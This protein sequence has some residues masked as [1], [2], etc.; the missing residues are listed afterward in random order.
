MLSE[1]R[2]R[3]LA[4][5]ESVE[6]HLA[7]GLNVVSGETG[8]GKSLI[9]T[10]V[11]LLLGARAR[12]GLVRHGAKEAIIEGRFLLHGQDLSDLTDL[13]E[14]DAEELVLRRVISPSGSSR[15]YL[16]GNL[17][18]IGL[19][20][21]VGARLV[22]VHGQ[23]QSLAASEEQRR[24]LDAFGNSE[25]LQADWA[26]DHESLRALEERLA[27]AEDEEVSR[28]ER[29]DYLR[30]QIAD[31]EA[32]APEV[33]EEAELEGELRLLEGAEELEAG[34]AEA[35]RRLTED[36][37]AL[38]S[39]CARLA[40]KL[41]DATAGQPVLG[42]LIERLDALAIEADDLG[43]EC[44]RHLDRLDRDPARQGEAEQRLDALRGL[45]RRHRVPA[46]E[47]PARL[48]AL[49]AEADE[50]EGGAAT[51][52]A[53]KAE[54]QTLL[55]RL[56]KTGKAL[57]T[58]RQKA[59]GT[60][61]T[62]ITEGLAELRMD[63]ATV[64]FDCGPKSFPRA[65]DPADA[66]ATGPFPVRLLVAANPGEPAQP[67]ERVASGGESARI[68]LAIKGALAGAHKRP[69]LIF[70][71]IDAGIGGRV[72]LP[73]GRRIARIADHHQ[74]LVVTHLPQV[75][76]FAAR[77]LRVHKVVAEGR[78]HTEVQVLERKEREVELA[79]ML[80]AGGAEKAA[81]AQAR[82]LLE[83]AGA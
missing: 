81:R 40:R 82:A 6:V 57:L 49:Q 54:R 65:F 46:D 67:L 50:L 79:A 78:T 62:A 32:L 55:E 73:F 20:Q 44:S 2:L 4:L 9:L 70:D 43:A 28:L 80:G 31:L 38:A 64:T 41:R 3:D 63:R 66:P 83:E 59:A 16:D 25:G 22:D 29:L 53:M 51:P 21:K 75:A 1:V 72:G 52:A 69:L 34:L 10:G 8:E 15:A 61:A 19:L 23:N 60:L 14:P 58:A 30:F 11:G 48:E 42:D 24:V 47:L 35:G 77:H 26:R 39:Q 12:K 36:E 5:L 68:L 27:R 74:V 71:E 17:C 7:P 13:L 37:D 56:K 45:A 33:G 76:A 18:P